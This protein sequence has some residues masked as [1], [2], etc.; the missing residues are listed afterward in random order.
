MTPEPNTTTSNPVTAIS[1][2]YDQLRKI[3]NDVIALAEQ[4]P[5]YVWAAL[6]A[7]LLFKDRGNE[8]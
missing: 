2:G 3:L 8:R 1:A 4:T 5:W 6:A 7:L